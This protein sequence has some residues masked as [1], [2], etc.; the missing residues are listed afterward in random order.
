MLKW[1]KDAKSQWVLP[2]GSDYIIDRQSNQ[3]V[4]L[5]T[6]Q[7]HE[8]VS[9]FL[10]F[11][12]QPAIQCLIKTRFLDI[13]YTDEMALGAN[14]NSLNNRIGTLN[15]GPSSGTS[16]TGSASSSFKDPAHG[17]SF[18]GGA[19]ILG[20]VSG[21]PGSTIL[22]LVGRKTDPAYQLTIAA[23]ETSSKTKILSAPHVLAINNKEA[24]V[25]ITTHFSYITDL[26]PI[27]NTTVAGQGTAV[28]STSGFIPEFDDENIGFTLTV[29]PSIGRDLKTINLHLKPIIDALSPGQSIAQFQTFEVSTT[30]NNAN[31]PT[32][33]R[34]SID[35]RSLE[36][37]VVLED[38]GYCIIGGLMTNTEKVSNNRVPGLHKIP[39]LGNLFKSTDKTKDK[40]S[41]MIIV[42]A[43]IIAP[44]GR[45]YHTKQMIDDVDIREGGS[46]KAPNQVN[47]SFPMHQVNN[48]NFGSAPFEGGSSSATQ[49]AVPFPSDPAKAYAQT[50]DMARS[51]A[52]NRILIESSNERT[53]TLSNRERMERLASTTPRTTPVRVVNAWSVPVEEKTG[54]SV[55]SRNT[56]APSNEAGEIVPLR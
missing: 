55:A 5:T 24:V 6:P 56:T 2:E 44:S 32:I 36:T 53:S 3:L 25:D 19:N 39:F 11:F 43:S 45:T 50:Q 46:N 30:A 41:L 1:M 13:Q 14:L 17:F 52:N 23:L 48:Q 34:P 51:R 37:D 20:A 27:Q 9:Q 8:R 18:A 42:E 12:D 29:T 54:E 26:R 47:D 35:Q 21:S 15:T 33:R 31:P 7:G 38:N 28:Q 16:T 40:R 10:D 4:V 22:S 49:K